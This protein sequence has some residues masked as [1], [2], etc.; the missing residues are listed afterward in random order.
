MTISVTAAFLTLARLSRHAF[1]HCLSV[2]FSSLAN[3]YFCITCFSISTVTFFLTFSLLL[4]IRYRNYNL[5]PKHDCL[6]QI[7]EAFC[8]FFFTNC[9][10]QIKSCTRP[11]FPFLLILV[12]L[13]S[14][15]LDMYI[16]W[17]LQDHLFSFGVPL[18]LNHQ[19][20]PCFVNTDTSK[21]VQNLLSDTCLSLAIINSSDTRMGCQT[22]V[23]I[24]LQQSFLC[25]SPALLFS[26][27]IKTTCRSSS[28][29]ALFSYLFVAVANLILQQFLLVGLILPSFF[30]FVLK[31]FYHPLL[32][33][34]F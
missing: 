25:P 2:Y 26:I 28:I 32:P 31:Y 8:S 12:L 9:F 10:E 7:S 14:R 20:F 34:I 13:C 33:F 19:S 16:S 3:K 15:H 6:L 5:S 11:S 24:P 21:F 17:C 4:L 22:H 29:H 30:W 18:S 23:S 27:I 1:F